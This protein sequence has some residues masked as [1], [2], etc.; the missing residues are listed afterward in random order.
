MDKGKLTMDL[1]DKMTKTVKENFDIEIEMMQGEIE[2]LPD[3]R[4][5]YTLEV[6][7]EKGKVII[8]FILAVMFRNNKINNN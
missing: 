2:K 7:E 1:T 5:R 8:Q 3:G 4:T 6:N